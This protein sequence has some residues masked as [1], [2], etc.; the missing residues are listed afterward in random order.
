MSDG[1]A[2]VPASLSP[3]P[4]AAEITVNL[5]NLRPDIRS[6]WDELKQHD[7]LFLLTLRPPDSITANYMAQA[8]RR[9]GRGGAGSGPG[10]RYSMLAGVGAS[11]FGHH[12]HKLSVASLCCCRMARAPRRAAWE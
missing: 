8:S 1:P 7:V 9:G 6:E 3:P 10:L 2:L 4:P 12:T 5:S 11:H